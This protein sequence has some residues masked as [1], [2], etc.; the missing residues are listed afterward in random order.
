MLVTYKIM[1]KNLANLSASVESDVSNVVCSCSLEGTI[2][3]CFCLSVLF[4]AII[5]DLK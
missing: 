3:W 1:G 2:F 5:T 4:D